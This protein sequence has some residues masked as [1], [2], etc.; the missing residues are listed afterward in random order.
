LNHTQVLA[1][2][3][4][5]LG[6]ENQHFCENYRK[7]LVF[8]PPSLR[9]VGISLFCKRLDLGKHSGRVVLINSFEMRVMVRSKMS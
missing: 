7:T 5:F 8:I 3:N 4:A 2:L 6:H 1:F 9:D